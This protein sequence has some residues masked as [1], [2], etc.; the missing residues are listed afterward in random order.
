MKHKFKTRYDGND[1]R[2][3]LDVPGESKTQQQFREE[4][5]I[6]NIMAKYKKTGVVN[7]LNNTPPTYGDFSNVDDYQTSLHKIQNA[8]ESFN[9]LPSHI[10]KKFSNDP[11]NLVAYLSD[12][13]NLEESYELGLRVR[14]PKNPMEEAFA[15]ALDTNDKKR[16]AATK[17]DAADPKAGGKGDA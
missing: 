2:H 8:H 9:Q 14:T 17:T 3:G 1:N 10:R 15:N 16:K 7:H 5:D 13:T 4:C 12:K 11:A 6:N